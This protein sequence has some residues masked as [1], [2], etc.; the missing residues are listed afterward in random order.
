MKKASMGIF[1]NKRLGDECCLN[2]SEKFEFGNSSI[3]VNHGKKPK[4]TNHQIYVVQLDS[5]DG[6]ECVHK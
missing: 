1:N 3:L 6:E 2:L 5:T 4:Q